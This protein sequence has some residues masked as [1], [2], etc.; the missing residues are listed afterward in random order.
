P[1]PEDAPALARFAR[2]GLVAGQ[3]F[4]ASKLNAVFAK[5]IPEIGFDRILAQYKINKEVKDINGWGFTTKTGLYGT[6]SRIRELITP[7][8]LGG[9]GRRDAVYATSL[10][11]ANRSDYHGSNNYVMRF[12]KGKLPP[13]EAFWSVTMYNS[14]FFFVENPINR[15]SISPRQHL[16]PNPDG[17][18]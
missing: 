15:Y 14:Q 12:A 16:K 13:A 5:R 4:D 2:I 11:D 3:D 1:A 18:V 6:N 10:K 17:S 7:I 9:N 8:G